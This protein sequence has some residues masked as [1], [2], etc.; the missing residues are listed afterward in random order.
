MKNPQSEQWHQIAVEQVVRDFETHPERGLQESEAKQRQEQYGR[1]AL[2]PP[3]GQSALVRFLLQFN[4][5]LVYIL[6]GAGV[7]TAGLQE[8]VDSIVIFGVVL[9]NGLIGFVQESKAVKAIQAL[10]HAMTS[11]ATVIRDGQK[12]RVGADELT[13]GDVV[14]LQSGDKVPADLRLV[15]SRELQINESALTGESVAVEKRTETLGGDTL[16][17]DRVNMA[18]SS[19]LVTYGTGVGVV[20]AIG[21]H[22]E[23]GRINELIST[24]EVLDTP[25]TK[26]M[27][28]FSQVCLCDSGHGRAD[29][30]RGC[31]AAKPG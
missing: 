31:S 1:N 21:D 16:L 4:Q 29:F 30:G 24:A 17:A 11:S 12:K 13:L 18:Y 23:I 8:W 19:T 3:K 9:V 27:A 20:I 25:L 5:P 22:T 26:R 28:A 2:T 10:A 6:I 15:H 14:V 7:V